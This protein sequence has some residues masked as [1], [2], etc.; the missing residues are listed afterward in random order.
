MPL[1]KSRKNVAL[2]TRHG[3]FTEEEVVTRTEILLDNYCKVL[4][5]ESM[6]MQEMIVRDVIPAVNKY[7]KDLSESINAAVAACPAANLSA[8]ADLV[9]KLSALIAEAYKQAANLKSATEKTERTADVEKKAMAYK[10]K[11]IPEMK[12]LR[13]GAD[14]MEPLPAPKNAPSPPSGEILFP[15]K[16]KKI[17]KKNRRVTAVFLLPFKS[18]HFNSRPRSP[19][20]RRPSKLRFL[21][22]VHSVLLPPPRPSCA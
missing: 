10:D 8:Q 22:R 19:L 15:V 11:V 7:V 21:S 20:F 18:K 5:I 1:S 4:H 6:T 14:T 9:N 16:K 2:F 17:P 12:S 3:V 13:R